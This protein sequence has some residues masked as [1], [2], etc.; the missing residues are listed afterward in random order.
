MSTISPAQRAVELINNSLYA[1]IA[2]CSNNQ[3]WN[4]PAT[5]WPDAQ[6]N[7]YWSS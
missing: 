2:S 6:L 4:T 5:A 1:N 3:P 7:F